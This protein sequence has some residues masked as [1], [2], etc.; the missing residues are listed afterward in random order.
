MSFLNFS[1]VYFVWVVIGAAALVGAAWFSVRRRRRAIEVFAGPVIGPRLSDS[2]DRTR[3][4]RRTVVFFLGMGFVA[5]AAARPW[6]GRRLVRTPRHSRDLLVAV[7]CSKSMLA[8][9]VAP[10][11]LDFAKWW[12]RKLVSECPGDRFGLI[13]FAGSAF[14]ECPLTVDRNTFFQFLDLLDTH[15]IPVGGTNIADALKTALKA[16]SGAE[17]GHRAVI[18]ISDGEELQGNAEATIG[19]FR[20]R[21]IPLFVVGLGNPEHPTVIQLPDGDFVRDKQG[22]IVET[23][24]NEAG[25]R[26]LSRATGGIYVRATTVR[27]NLAPVLRRVRALTPE[28]HRAASSRRPVERYQIPLFAGVVLLMF[29]LG[30]GER[31]KPGARRG[32]SLGAGLAVGLAFGLLAG[33]AA[34]AGG[35]GKASPPPAPATSG[36]AGAA[37]SEAFP[38]QILPAPGARLNPPGRRGPPPGRTPSD[39]AG[40]AA[41]QAAAQARQAAELQREIAATRKELKAAACDQRARL[42][43]NLGYLYQRAGKADEAIAEYEKAIGLGG[44]QPEVLARAYWNLGV[45]RHMQARRILARTPDAAIKSLDQA[46]EAYREALRRAPG[47]RALA[48][49]M[50]ILDRDRALARKVQK[51]LKKLR[52]LRKDAVEKTTKALK[53]QA[54]ANREKDSNRA[55]QE[56]AR[57]RRRTQEAEQAA[58]KLAGTLKKLGA[59]Q[60]AQAAQKA[61]SELRHAM[62]EQDKAVQSVRS[63]ESRTQAAKKAAEHLKKALE[64]LG[65]KPKGKPNSQKTKSGKSGKPR[66][67]RE[68]QNRAGNGKKQN[69]RQ[70]PMQAGKDMMKKLQQQAA[71]KKQDGKQGKKVAPIDPA[72]AAAILQR[73]QEKEEDLRKALLERQRRQYRLHPVERDW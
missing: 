35:E 58:K 48:A 37:G 24:L 40:G 15:T 56:T 73:M 39:S 32:S 20:K 54:A 36:K 1:I 72:R 5:L 55:R 26:A 67:N 44:G 27:P 71:R 45:L 8:R 23:R 63:P 51:L 31:R 7:D 49:N 29:W 62:E 14:L 34:R 69:G 42:H 30:M 66:K 6:W 47:N 41:A 17:S 53:E 4:R 65:A 16:F 70:R 38:Y 46:A 60:P 10:T 13:A 43:F 3:R 61:D 50:E 19:E 18:L 52:E 21:R 68:N 25:L 12:I 64:L 28:K 33:A 59:K 9:D 11:R 57:A 22:K 2:L